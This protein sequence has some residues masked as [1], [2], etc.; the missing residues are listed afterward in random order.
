[1]SERCWF[2]EYAVGWCGPALKVSGWSESHNTLHLGLVA[3]DLYI[4]IPQWFI[5][6]YDVERGFGFNF[7]DT[8]LHLSWGRKYKVLWYPWSWEHYKR[9]ELV[10]NMQ[11]PRGIGG[12]EPAFVELP[13]RANH[14][15]LGTKHTA[16]Y[17]YVRKN[18]EIQ[19]RVATVYVSRTECRWR[20]FQWLPWPRKV[21]TD[22]C[23][24][25][26]DEVGESSGSWKGGTVG[27]GYDMLPGET[28][29]DT[30]R[31]MERQRTFR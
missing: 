13:R 3:C 11:W 9:W 17:T 12:M 16:D 7:C 2:G 25:F 1:M 24:S 23:V 21:S 27:C 5:R 31:R 6:G 8:A 20:W 4:Y 22:I 15:A 26:D 14:G 29:L 28:W 30:L 10:D 19:K 18:G